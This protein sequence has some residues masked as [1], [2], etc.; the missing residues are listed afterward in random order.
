[1]VRVFPRKN[2]WIPKDDLSFVGWPP[3]FRPKDQLVMVSVVFTWDIEMGQRLQKAWSVYFSDVRLGGPAM[4]NPGAEFVPG[5]FIKKGVTITSRGCSK[6]CPWCYVPKREGPIR[7]LSIQPGN[8]IQDNNLLACSREHIFK[9]FNMLKSQKK[10]KFSG[11]ID[12]TL[13]KDWHRPLF[14]SIKLHEIWLACDNK[15]ALAPLS[16]AAKILNGISINKKRCY[17]MIGFNGEGLAQAESRLEAV[18]KLGFLPFC[19]LYQP[20]HK[21]AYGKEW[22]ALARKWSRPA[23]YRST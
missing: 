4:N 2:K 5:R 17:V 14:D 18:Y 19:Q 21:I 9:V 10:I 8:I 12:A 6:R 7:E 16:R 23:A 22:R 15:A 1:M 11:G 20:S 3:L 13:L